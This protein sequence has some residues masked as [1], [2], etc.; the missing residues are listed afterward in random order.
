MNS[1]FRKEVLESRRNQWLGGISLVQPLRGWLLAGFVVS[2]ALVVLA[3]LYFGDYTRRSR[4]SGQL[5]PSA[6]LATVMAPAAGVIERSLVDEGE[7]VE[8]GQA[9][10]VVSVPRA[11]AS[12]QN[13]AEVLNEVLQRRQ[14]GAAREA[15]SQEELMRAQ[16]A[17][18]ERQLRIARQ[19]LDG[20]EKE[21]ATRDEQVRLAQKILERYRRLS[22]DHYISEL[23]L[24]QQEQ[25]VLDQIA[26]RQG[27][28][29]QHRAILRTIAQLE[30]RLAEMPAQQATQNA[31]LEQELAVIARDRVQAQTRAE[32]LVQAPAAGIVASRQVEPGQAVQAGQPLLTLL[33]EGPGLEAQLLLPSRAIGFIEPGDSVLL[34]YQAFPH[35]KFGHHRGTVSQVSR[36]ALAAQESRSLTGAGGSG[37]PV[38]RVRVDLEAQSIMAYGKPNR[39]APG[40]W[41]RRISWGKAE[42]C[43]NGS[44]SRFIRSLD[45]LVAV[46]RSDRTFQLTNPPGM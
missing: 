24:Q 10:A 27:L 7:S 41:S 42:S 28:E 12:G 8:Q 32:L 1:L 11:L 33:P 34:R 17:G 36:S 39:C 3:F 4:V 40:C 45:R 2:A 5:V 30:Q 31:V 37:E 43:M 29:R 23:E 26:A 46:R 35:Q 6:G 20:I 21:A 25:V 13:V 15:Q 38:Y 16:V 44:W 9:L 22:G 14:A 18:I 19:E